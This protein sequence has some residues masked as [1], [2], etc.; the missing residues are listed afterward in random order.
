MDETNPYALFQVFNNRVIYI[1]S[2]TTP[3]EAKRYVAH[4]YSSPSCLQWEG[5]L[6]LDIYGHTVDVDFN[7]IDIPF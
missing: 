1:T 4:I 3:L 7:V 6:L 2:T 5:W